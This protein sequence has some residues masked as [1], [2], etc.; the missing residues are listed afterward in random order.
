MQKSNS[1]TSITSII[2]H[3]LLED[4]ASTTF[5]INGLLEDELSLQGMI[6][7]VCANECV[8][9][10]YIRPTMYADNWIPR[11]SAEDFY[12]LYSMYA[13]TLKKLLNIINEGGAIEKEYV[14]GH[15]VIQAGK[16]TTCY[17]NV[18]R[19]SNEYA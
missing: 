5:V 2:V 19:S 7:A 11:Y 16:K 3:T 12:S 6:H 13:D 8:H 14:G 4:D 18:S 15:P 9:K 10:K 1:D 17:N